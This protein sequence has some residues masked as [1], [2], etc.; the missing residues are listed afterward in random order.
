MQYCNSFMVM[1]IKHLVLLLLHYPNLH[2]KRVLWY[3]FVNACKIKRVVASRII[4]YWRQCPILTFLWVLYVL[5]CHF[6]LDLNVNI[7]LFFLLQ[8]KKSF[9]N[10]NVSCILTLPIYMKQGYGKMLI[11]FSK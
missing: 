5:H 9:L 3:F 10:Y 8:E 1:Q 7:Y 11:D 4:V 2:F 6:G